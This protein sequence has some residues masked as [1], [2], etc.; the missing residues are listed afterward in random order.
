MD[1][2]KRLKHMM[3]LKASVQN[4]PLSLPPTFHCPKWFIWPSP[5]SLGVGMTPCIYA[6]PGAQQR[7]CDKECA[8]I[9]YYGKGA[10]SW[11]QWSKLSPI[12]FYLFSLI[13]GK[14]LSLLTLPLSP[15]SS[16]SLVSCLVSSSSTAYFITSNS[17]EKVLSWSCNVK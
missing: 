9:I 8:C 13:K 15:T 7:A 17:T 3:L 16:Q 6:P 10:K 5:E 4:Q 11:E 2:E 12:S 1:E 14:T